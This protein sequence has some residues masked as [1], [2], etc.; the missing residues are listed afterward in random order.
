MADNINLPSGDGLGPEVALDDIGGVKYPRSKITIGDDGVNDG[1]VSASNPLPVTGTIAV[2]GVAT[3]ANQATIIGHV[4]GIESLLTTI[5]AD[6][7]ALASVDFV[8]GSDVV[9]L[10]VIG[11]GVE[12]SALRVTL[13]NDSTGVLSVD[14]NSGSLTV[15]A[16]VDTP[17]FVRLSDGSAAISTLPVSLA[18]VPSHDVTNAGTFAVQASQA[19]TWNVTNISGTIS[20]PTGAS[21][22]ANQATIIGH[23]DGV[24]GLLT[25]IDADTGTLAGIDFVTGSDVTSLGV[26]GGGLEAPALRVTIA[27]DSTGVISV[28]DNGSSLTVDGS[29]SISGNVTVINAGTFATQATLQAGTAYVGKVRLTDGTTDAEVVPLTGYN[30][31]AV[32]IVD[33]NGD[34]ITSF[35]GGTQ[36]TEGD[37]DA[38]ITGTAMLMEGAAN[39]LV[40][41]QGTVADGLLVNLG[42][43]NDV[44][45]TGTVTANA[46]MGTFAISA[47]ALPLP[48]GA[49][50]SAN[51]TTIIGHLDGVEGLLTTIDADTGTLAAIDFATGSDVASLGVTGGGVEASAL[52]VTIA[53]DS[54]GVISIDDNGG[55]ITV[56][57]TVAISG[58]V[59]VGSHDVTNAGTFATQATLQAGTAYA[60]KVRLTDGT[61]DTDIRDL[62]NSNALNV[63][64]VDGSGDQITSFGG[65]TQYTEGDID[66]TIIGT[67]IMWEDSGNTLTTVSAV[68][69]LPIGDGGG[70][71]TVDN[72]GTFAVQAA[73]NGTWN[74]TNISGT[75]SLPT[76]A[77][78]AANQTTIISHLDGVEGLLT[79]IDADTGALAA[80]DFATG[81]DVAS[82]AVVGGGLEAT[83]L[84]VTIANDSTGVVSIDDNGGSITVDGTVAISGTVAVTDNGGSL[85]VDNGGTFVVQENGAALTS[86]QLIDDVVGTSH[87]AAPSKIAVVGGKYS[88][89]P[90]TLDDGDVCSLRINVDQALVVCD[91]G[92]KATI[93]STSET[94]PATDTATSG[95]NGRLQRIAQNITSLSGQIPSS[96]GIKTAANSLSVA[97]ASDAVFAAAQNGTWNITNISGTISL[98]T[99]AA[100][101]AKQPALGTAGTASSDV[102]TVQGIASMTALKV[103]GSAVTQP[104]SGTVTATISSGATAIAKA[105]DIASADGDVG[106]PAM[107]VRKATPANTS[108]TDGDYEMLQMSAGRLWTST[109][110]D[111]ALPAGTNEIGKLA[112]NSGVIIGE[113]EIASAQTLSTLTGS[114]VAHDGVDTGKPHKIGARASTSIS[115]KTMVAN[116]DRT[117][118][119]AGVDGVLITRQHSNLE[120]VVQERKTNTNGASTAMTSELAAPGSGI[121]LWITGVCIA[122][123]STTDITVDL[124]DGASGTV[125]WT[126]SAPGGGGC[127]CQFNPPLRLSANTALAFDG[128]AA[129]NTL[130]VSANGFKSKV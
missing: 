73:Q 103:D 86:L 123:S 15:D 3:A 67:A 90:P 52:R 95:L 121:R 77:S 94:A 14:D 26:T 88:A 102:L 19:G 60:G 9:S 61:T 129:V 75:V 74:V 45:V 122:N 35:G 5:D 76:G 48:S 40:V 47:A 78:T 62:T 64:I 42:S 37:T 32:A 96:L 116:N 12:A 117:D 4:D 43:N 66:A 36:Y 104:V 25:T 91:E 87:D 105:E 125:L 99:G 30:A 20:L 85:T 16:P 101:A 79:T 56:D 59:T 72:A 93:G 6:T 107:A 63:A 38:T 28:D 82:L 7:S 120:D 57:G 89:I 51:Q 18:S 68:K 54:T 114:S 128:S 24:E 27:N 41:V 118:L 58:T 84:R 53:N 1:D 111:T 106:V 112:A 49:S 109:T 22:A 2:T 80:I 50:T 21:T 119:F 92:Q 17:V 127:N 29:V 83:A 10:G 130:T 46:G 31:Q 100:T 126:L 34:Q 69:P 113:V 11:G 33:N 81:A 70:S 110:I 115:G 44:T 98:P 8:T 23:L 71:I 65:G 108:G 39:A 55:S 13:A 124:Q 97:P